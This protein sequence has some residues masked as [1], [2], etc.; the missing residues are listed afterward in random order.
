MESV[1]QQHNTMNTLE[2]ISSLSTL[3]QSAQTLL[4]PDNSPP[5]DT[6]VSLNDLFD[7]LS[8]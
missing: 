4:G 3:I 2:R 6:E 8:R 7:L 5:P 1:R